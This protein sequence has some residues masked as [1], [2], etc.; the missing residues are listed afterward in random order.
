M[1][2]IK[3]FKGIRPVKEKS[4]QVASPPYDVI[5]RDEAKELGKDNPNSFIHVV[6]PEIDCSDD[7][8]EYDSQVIQK[9]KENIQRLF[10]Q[11]ILFQDPERY[12]YVYAQTMN[13]ETQYGLVSCAYVDDYVNDRIKKHELTRPDKEEGRKKHVRESN[14][15]YEPVFFAYRSQKEIND[16]INEVVT[17][18]DPEYDFTDE[19]EFGH[20]FWVI[21]DKD[22]NDR[23]EQLFKEKVPYTYVADGHHR[24][25]A[26]AL[27]GEERKQNNPDHTGNE[28]YNYF[29][30]VHFPEDQLH[31]LD[32]N[33]V[34]KDLNGL[35]KEDFLRQLQESFTIE[36]WGS[37][38]YKPDEKHTFGMYLDGQWYKLT[39][40]E[41]TYT[42][43][44]IG[45]LDVTVL[46]KC[47]LEPILNIQDLRKSKRIDF[48]GGIRG[49]E[50]LKKQVDSG[51]M[52][53]SF[54]LY[55]VSMKEIIDIADAGEIM[56]PKTTWF[57]PKLKSGLIV[58]S[59]TDE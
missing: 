43:D 33:R 16:I 8:G 37:E 39:A 35:S 56:P 1:V 12:M 28:E 46:S 6:K 17:N 27:V 22:K 13:G 32:Y 7:V 23:L 11:K 54:A 52:A 50:P 44:P 18:N 29:L 2:V 48:I 21:K 59:L 20:T 26:A 24:T 36:E 51:E 4:E 45:Q 15:H 10:D 58:H 19:N 25:A 30:A 14:M 57:E 47:V 55:P 5:E 49:L 9:G 53:V 3:P 31:I 40:K 34:V 38:P 41:G 42:N